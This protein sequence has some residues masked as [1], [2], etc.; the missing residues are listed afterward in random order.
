MTDIVIVGAGVIGLMTA[1]NWLVP[2][3]RLLFW[4]AVPPL[5]KPPGPGGA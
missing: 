5:E 2:A 1:V 4:S 3:S